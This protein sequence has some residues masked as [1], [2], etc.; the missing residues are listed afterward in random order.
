MTYTPY[1]KMNTDHHDNSYHR[2]IEKLQKLPGIGERTAT[3]LAM[4]ILRSEGDYAKDLAQS[5]FDAKSKIG[6]CKLCQDLTENE[7][8]RRCR[9]EHRDASVVC[10]VE[11][12][13]S[14]EALEQTGHYRGRYYI[15]HGSLSPMQAIGPETLDLQRLRKRIEQDMQIREM[16]LAFDSDPEGEATTL[17][18]KEYLQDLNI[19]MTRMALGI[20]VG[21]H[22]QYTDPLTLSRALSSRH[23]LGREL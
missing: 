17:Y 2:L 4:Y 7:I 21:A 20:P 6:F 9:D 3:R 11:D 23:E 22:I 15:L 19:K 10:L 13:A 18:L 1:H 12:P 5:I 16:I 14:M 8:C